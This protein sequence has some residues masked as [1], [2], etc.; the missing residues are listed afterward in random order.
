MFPE[1]ATETCQ[2]TP[3]KTVFPM[4]GKLARTVILVQTEIVEQQNANKTKKES[5][6]ALPLAGTGAN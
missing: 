4:S 5:T 6:V 1:R 2:A 3:I